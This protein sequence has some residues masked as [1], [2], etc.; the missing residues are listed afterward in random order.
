MAWSKQTLY[1]SFKAGESVTLQGFGGFYV[2][3]E[4]A[5]WAFKFNPGQRLRALLAG[6]RR[7]G[8]ERY[9][10]GG[11]GQCSGN[12]ANR[13]SPSPIV[14]LQSGKLFGRF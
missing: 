6:H 12:G 1:E 11:V 8:S 7:R 14:L 10:P 3:P 9:M 5:S 4:S 13:L 2:R